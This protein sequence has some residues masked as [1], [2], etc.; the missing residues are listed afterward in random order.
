[1]ALQVWLPLNGDLTQQGL[2]GVQP[3][4][5]S[6]TYTTGKIGQ[7]LLLDK[8]IDTTLPATNWDYIT[9]SCSFGCWI[10]VSSAD[11]QAIANGENFDSTD[12]AMGG[13]LLGKDSYGGAALRWK[14]NN[15]S[16]SKTITQVVLYGH[17]RNTS[18]NSQTTDNYIIPFDTW[19]HVMLIVNRTTQLMSLYINGELF[20]E[21]KINGVTGTFSTGNFLICQ[22]SWDGGNGV[23]SPGK[24]SLN[25]VRVYNH[26]LS[27]KEVKE[28]SKGLVLHYRLAG[29]GQENLLTDSLG[30]FSGTM[31]ETSNSIDFKKWNGFTVNANEVYT[32]SYEAKATKNG[33]ILANF[34]YNNDSGIVQCA[35]TETSS[36]ASGTDANGRC[37]HILTTQYKKYWVRWTFNSTT[38]S[39]EKVLLFRFNDSNSRRE[40]ITIKNVKLERGSISTPWCPNPA[41]ALYSAMGYNNNIEYDCSGYRRNGTK[42]GNITWDI[43]SPRYT[44]SYNFSNSG[45]IYNNSFGVTTK[46][47][48][49]SLWVKL[50]PATSQHFLF[51]T[52][53]SWT[54]NG[55][56]FYRSA[57]QLGLNCIFKSDG[58]SSYGSLSTAGLSANTWYMVTYTS[59]GTTIKRYL[60]GIYQNSLT[61]GKGGNTLN[62]VLYIANS[63]YNGTPASGN[64]EALISDVRFYATALS[65]SD[66]AELYHSAVIVDNTGK[67]YAYE[68]FEG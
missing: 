24:F 13:T 4:V 16:S 29:P 5:S 65:D 51:G 20:D 50:K 39:A 18:S 38:T 68:Y 66:I 34:F 32:L 25:D 17:I 54:N 48:T 47:Y 33:V 35:K 43:D 8:Q 14:T 44:T 28:L 10:K 2:S 36:G 31:P 30:E 1:M 27:K 11:L 57:N 45:Y 7:C 15:L 56:G 60:N 6:L 52:F 19:T 22:S 63:K 40:T 61:Y 41:D 53:D 55:I 3:N 26:A 9:N 58:E 37:T 62:P 23:S 12:T 49:I 42:S 46:E 59:D 67:N 21:K 64:E